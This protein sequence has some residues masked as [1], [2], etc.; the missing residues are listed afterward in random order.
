MQV[1]EKYSESAFKTE[2]VDVYKGS[3]HNVVHF[4]SFVSF[5][6]IRQDVIMRYRSDVVL[7]SS[8]ELERELEWKTI[9][10]P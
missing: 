7:I 3:I 1:S 9:L 2:L 6:V 4:S 5:R 8:N 10:G